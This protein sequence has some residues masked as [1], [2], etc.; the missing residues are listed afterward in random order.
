MSTL[1]TS[2]LILTTL[3]CVSPLLTL[4]HLWQMKEWRWDRLM[5]HL[6]TEGVFSTLVGKARYLIGA[7]WLLNGLLVFAFMSQS[8]ES[9]DLFFIVW[10]LALPTLLVLLGFLQWSMKRQ[11]MPVWT[12]KAQIMFLGCIIGTII[13]GWLCESFIGSGSEIVLPYMQSIILAL[14][15]LLLRPIDLFLKNR[16][17]ARATMLRAGHPDLTVI[18][19]TGSVGKTTTKEI[20]YHLLKDTGAI[21]TPLHVNTE[22]GVADWLIRT[23]V[24]EPRD[25]KRILIVE[26]GAYR[27][28]EIALLCEI[29]QPTI[30]IVTFVGKQHSALFGGEE[31]IARA[32]GELLASLPKD[33]YAFVNADSP[34]LDLLVKESTVKPTTIGTDH[35]ALIKA[36]DIEETGSG[37]R[38]SA[39]DTTF[40]V[41]MAGTHNITNILLAITT[42]KHLGTPLSALQKSLQNFTAFERTFTVRKER[43]I[44]ILDNSYNSSAESFDAGIDWAKR[45]PNREKILVMSGIIELGKD[46]ERVHRMIA[47]KASKIFERVYITQERFLPYFTPVFKERASLISP[48]HQP[49]SSGALLVCMGRMSS[50]TIEKFVKSSTK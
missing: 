32:K 28:G 49:L 23:L 33:G 1:G 15:W 22:M 7:L 39:F 35:R 48:K 27:T 4:L 30:G 8:I 37:I 11:P 38:F 13:A 16:I 3:A 25:S 2:F 42:A 41:P 34:L 45:Q 29:A 19:I 46:E 24:H 26:M 50:E 31:A 21:A 6:K 12:R 18:G 10:G 44:T 43:G 9:R 20:L 17:L 14:V 40:A 47:E 5:D 36:F